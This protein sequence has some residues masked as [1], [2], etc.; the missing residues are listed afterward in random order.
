[1][2]RDRIQPMFKPRW[3][4]RIAALADLYFSWYGLMWGLGLLSGLGLLGYVITSWVMEFLRHHSYISAVV[5]SFASIVVTAA[6]FLRIPLALILVFGGAAI[7]AVFFYQ[8]QLAL[9]MP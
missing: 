9:L 8:G 7:A 3:G 1:M 6:A 4:D 2:G 5:L